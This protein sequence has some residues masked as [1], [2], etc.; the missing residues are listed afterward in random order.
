MRCSRSFL[1]EAVDQVA[2]PLD[3]GF[4]GALTPVARPALRAKKALR[5]KA[6]RSRRTCRR[7][8]LQVKGCDP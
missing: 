8:R 4:H 6:F 2:A 5:G 3:R 1:D 7:S